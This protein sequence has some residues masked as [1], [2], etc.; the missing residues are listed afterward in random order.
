LSVPAAPVRSPARRRR[1]TFHGSFPATRRNRAARAKGNATHLRR[2]NAQ[3]SAPRGR[4]LRPSRAARSHSRQR[5]N[6]SP[7]SR[8]ETAESSLIALVPLELF[9]AEG[10]R[11]ASP[12]GSPP[13][14]QGGYPDPSLSAR[15]LRFV[16]M[17]KVSQTN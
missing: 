11:R 3:I 17:S 10:L 4:A 12:V 5:R 7:C 8:L 14:P 9:P 13:P 1:R 6:E 2:S 15:S 16:H